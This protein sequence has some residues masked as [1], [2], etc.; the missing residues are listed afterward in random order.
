ML[1]CLASVLEQL[2]LALEHVLKC[3]VH[4]A[5]FGL[6]LTD[7]AVELVLHQI[8]KGKSADLRMFTNKREGYPHESALIKTLGREF[9]AK[10]KFARIEGCLDDTHT[11][12]V[13]QA[14]EDAGWQVREEIEPTE[15]LN[16]KF[17][18]DYGDIDVLAWNTERKEII[19]AECKDLSLARNHTEVAHML[20][21]FQ[22]KTNKKCEPD[23]LRRHLDRVQLLTDH[24]AQLGKFCGVDA[25]IIRSALICSGA[26]PMQ[27]IKIDALSD[28]FVGDVAE[29]INMLE[30]RKV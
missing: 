3:D 22:G 29:L 18:I 25:P 5:R 23:K 6:M 11:H 26:V 19:T 12:A 30:G 13:T 28:T 1:L 4:N 9:D 15:I 27:Y 21:E 17:P 10:V 24:V 16:Q 2:D 20:S 8:T 14:L 7:N